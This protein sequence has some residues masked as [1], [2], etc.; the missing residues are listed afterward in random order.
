MT[1]FLK[2]FITLYNLKYHSITEVVKGDTL[3]S[4]Q[5]IVNAVTNDNFEQILELSFRPVKKELIEKQGSA[6]G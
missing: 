2:L 6:E 4:R 5:K 3:Q 1:V